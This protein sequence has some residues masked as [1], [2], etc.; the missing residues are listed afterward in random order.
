MIQQ[1]Y[2]KSIKRQRAI[3]PVSLLILGVSLGTCSII[4]YFLLTTHKNRNINS[5]QNEYVI[6]INNIVQLRMN[7]LVAGVV[8][9]STFV[10]MFPNC[11]DLEMYFGPYT[12]D[13]F[14]WYPGL[15]HLEV[16]PSWVTR[17]HAFRDGASPVDDDSETLA[18]DFLVSDPVEAKVLLLER[19]IVLNSPFLM[20]GTNG[21]E[22]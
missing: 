16:N 7:E 11:T 8:S 3:V 5:V 21:S 20:A 4:L 14:K 17:F 9:L 15:I 22:D 18:F 6:P 2:V 12:D 19:S 13:L 10:S 1:S